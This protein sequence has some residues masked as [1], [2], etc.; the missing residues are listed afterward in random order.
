VQ[1]NFYDQQ[2]KDRYKIFETFGAG[3]N[4]QSGLTLVPGSVYETLP[5]GGFHGEL[6]QVDLKSGQQTILYTFNDGRDGNYAV[7]ALTYYQGAF[8]SVTSGGGGACNCGTVFKF[9][10]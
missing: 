4:Y 7:S 6:V 3:Q 2:A 5:E 9:V 10:P 8:Y 1:H